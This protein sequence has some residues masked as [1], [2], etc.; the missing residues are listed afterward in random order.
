MKAAMLPEWLTVN[1]A[2]LSPHVMHCHQYLD[3]EAAG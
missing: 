2:G 1:Q 3:I